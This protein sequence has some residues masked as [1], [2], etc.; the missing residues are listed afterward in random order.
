MRTVTVPS[1]LQQYFFTTKKPTSVSLGRGGQK[2]PLIVFGGFFS[3]PPSLG[4][5]EGYR[6]IQGQLLQGFLIFCSNCVL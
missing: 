2:N 1:P 5:V 6:Q 4:G 3:L